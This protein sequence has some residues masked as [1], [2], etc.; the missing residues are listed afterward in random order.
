MVKL[1]R[2]LRMVRIQIQFLFSLAEWQSNNLY[3]VKGEFFGFKMDGKKRVES[4]IKSSVANTQKIHDD[5]S[6]QM[7]K[8]LTAINEQSGQILDEALLRK[9]VC[10]LHNCNN[11]ILF[12]KNLIFDQ[13]HDQQTAMLICLNKLS[14]DLSARVLN[15]IEGWCRNADEKNQ[16]LE[17]NIS[18]VLKQW[19]SNEGAVKFQDCVCRILPQGLSRK[20]LDVYTAI[21]FNNS[22]NGI[23]LDELEIKCSH[24]T[25]NELNEITQCLAMAGFCYSTVD[26][27]HFKSSDDHTTCIA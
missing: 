15:V 11:T 19:K 24:V 18:N 20:Q 17:K 27:K 2:S 1:D 8:S 23:S 7:L 14:S 26:Y 22:E 13:V 16:Q 12:Y 5:L 4:I 9:V 10:F 21:H 3:N 6:I 25:R